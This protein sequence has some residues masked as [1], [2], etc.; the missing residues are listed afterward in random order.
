MHKKEIR[1]RRQETNL[2]LIIGGWTGLNNFRKVSRGLFAG[3]ES[4]KIITAADLVGL[5]LLQSQGN[6]LPSR[7]VGKICL[8]GLFEIEP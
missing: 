1:G 4:V 6:S 3:L 8:F 7:G 5:T 2:S